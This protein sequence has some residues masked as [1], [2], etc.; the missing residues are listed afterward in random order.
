LTASIRR[1]GWARKRLVIAGF[2][3][4]EVIEILQELVMRGDIVESCLP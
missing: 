2:L 3:Y 4:Y 1:L